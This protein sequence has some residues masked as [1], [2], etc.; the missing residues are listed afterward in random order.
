MISVYS[1]T[2]R[3]ADIELTAIFWQSIRMQIRYKC[4]RC[5]FIVNIKE[6]CEMRTIED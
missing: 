3:G 2:P 6:S 5:N 1:I 4:I